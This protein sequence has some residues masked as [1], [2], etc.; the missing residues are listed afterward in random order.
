MAREIDP[1]E[2]CILVAVD[3]GG[4]YLLG[5]EDSRGNTVAELAWPESWPQTVSPDY[6]R[7]AGFKILPA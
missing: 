2:S 5:V 7:V 1:P 6:L 4:G 3:T